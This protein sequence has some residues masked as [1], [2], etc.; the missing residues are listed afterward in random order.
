MLRID[1][2]VLERGHDVREQRGIDVAHVQLDRG[3]PSFRH[4]PLYGAGHF[5]ARQQLVDEAVPLAIVQR[6]ALAAN[7]LGDEKAVGAI[8][9]H[10]R[11]GVKL[12]QLQIGQHRAGVVREQQ[13]AAGRPGG[14]GC[15]CPQRR[16]AAGG[17]HRGGSEDLLAVEQLD[18]DRA[19]AIGEDRGR[20][21][22]LQH[23]DQLVLGHERA[24]FAD[25]P[26]TSRSA[27]GVDYPPGAVA[28][29]EPEGQ[30]AVAV[31]VEADAEM[32]QVAH[33]L[34]RLGAQRRGGR[35]ARSR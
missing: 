24:Q 14:V 2:R 26:P 25:Q 31:G 30:L 32:L 10:D 19:L 15:A 34:R 22:I 8:G 23:L 18:T 28:A 12:H 21:A 1:P 20:A 9:G 11:G 33:G 13:A 16:G 3:R 7:G 35:L 17:E 29:L 6:R 4:P 5:V 27:A